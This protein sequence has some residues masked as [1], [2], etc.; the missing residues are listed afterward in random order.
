MRMPLV[1]SY[2]ETKALVERI[3]KEYYLEFYAYL[4][5]PDAFI[6]KVSKVLVVVN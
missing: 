5:A 2:N 3:V 1:L 6:E 4:V